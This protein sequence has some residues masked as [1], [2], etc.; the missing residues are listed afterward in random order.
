MEVYDKN[1]LG[2]RDDDSMLMGGYYDQNAYMGAEITVTH[3]SLGDADD[4][5]DCRLLS[6]PTIDGNRQI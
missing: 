4:D 1:G 5:D 3:D 6:P 2:Y